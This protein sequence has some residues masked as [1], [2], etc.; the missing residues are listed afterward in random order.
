M[1]ISC[2]RFSDFSD[3]TPIT[4]SS[5][6]GDSLS[7]EQV[8]LYAISLPKTN[9]VAHVSSD[10]L[11]VRSSAD[12]IGSNI[13]GIL[14]ANDQVEILDTSTFDE[15]TFVYVKILSANDSN[16]VGVSGYVSAKYLND[17]AI[18]K[19]PEREKASKYT[20][21]T[22]VATEK[23]RVYR[24]CEKEEKCFNKMVFEQDVV[25]GE[26]DDG[27]KTDLGS[28]RITSWDKFYEI[29]GKYPAWYKPGYP[30]VP[31]PDKGL[32]AWFSED[33][34]PNKIG[35]MRGAFGWYTAK[36]GPNANGQWLHGTSGWGDNS[37]DFILIK[38]SLQGSII[39]LFTSIRSHGCTR[40]DNKSI[41]Y[42]R[43]LLP[44]GTPYLKVYAKEGVRYVKKIGYHREPGQWN[45]IITKK[46]AGKTNDHQL[47]DEEIVLAEST[48]PSDWIERGTF[49]VDQY[50]SPVAFHSSKKNSV[51]GDLYHL[52]ENA[53]SG[54]FLVD[55]GT[56]YNYHHPKGLGLG[57]YKDQLL[58][59]HMTTNNP[60]YYQLEID[61]P[62][63][64]EN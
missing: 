54:I 4:Y 57:G 8:G 56:L 60:S 24:Q 33:V 3:R 29:S 64:Y 40:I 27:T 19:S 62:L 39:N 10:R 18:V 6:T 35:Q 21:I 1:S 38:K 53:I 45:Y 16:L 37:R 13:L 63:K 43:S 59:P 42:L 20:I 26:D 55:E 31:G 9:T 61:A 47:A 32:S 22:N 51:G 28:F 34:M 2:A 7:S 58:P 48:D 30:D 46:G 52:G 17:K 41:A 50:P 12:V 14:N 25:N 44:V 5:E 23:I 49:E 15:T 11:R 36:V